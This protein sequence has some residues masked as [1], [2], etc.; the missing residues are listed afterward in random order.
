MFGS[1]LLR[2]RALVLSASAGTVGLS[3]ASHALTLDDVTIWTGD[4]SAASRAGLVID[5]AD[6]KSPVA[7]GYRFD[8]A[9]TGEDMLRAIATDRSELYMK[10]GAFALGTFTGRATFGIGLDRDADG[11]AIS[12]ATVFTAGIAETTDDNADGAV[13]TDLD[14]SYAEGWL[15]AG[16]WGYYVSDGASEWDFAST[17]FTDRFLQDG[18]WDGF[19][20]QP[21][22]SGGVPSLSVPEPSS[23]L[24]LGLAGLAMI[25]RRRNT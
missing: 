14:D 1:V 22:F 10:T 9:A 7:Y 3:G 13:S 23:A 11:F 12:D 18:D 25:R 21:S 5:W 6:G 16:F 4:E 17:G 20:Y 8:G 15:T 24:L 2:S 19:A